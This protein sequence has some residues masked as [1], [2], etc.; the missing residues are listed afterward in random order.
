[1]LKKNQKIETTKIIKSMEDQIVE[2]DLKWKRAL[3]DYQ[4]LEKRNRDQ[5]S[6]L[7]QLASLSIV[8]RLLPIYDHLVLAANH[9]NDPGLL[10][11][12][13]QF[14]DALEA[15]GVTEI[16]ALGLPYDART[17]E[18][19]EQVPGE[20]NIVM[21]INNQG[22]TIGSRVIRPARVKV[23]IGEPIN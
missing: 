17:M 13:K 11:V 1:M 20:K 16:K 4:N 8:E 5:Q 21:E 22:F 12:V 7:T 6:L 23:G 10:M 2:L 3:A 9:I 15:E 18:C 14:S 19:V